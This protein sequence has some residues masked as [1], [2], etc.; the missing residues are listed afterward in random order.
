MLTHAHMLRAA[1]SAWGGRPAIS[2]FDRPTVTYAELADQ[3]W[4][5]A[6]GLRAAGIEPGDRVAW[7]SSNRD[8][9]L[10]AYYGTAIAGIVFAPLNYWLRPHEMRPLLE[11]V[12]PRLA[13]VEPAHLAVFEEAADGLECQLIC[14]DDRRSTESS[15]P[16][17]RLARLRRARPAL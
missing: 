8:E 1:V 16:E 11:L 17:R 2:S 15:R 3:S 5:L 13:F 9:Y 4:R 6:G 12:Q 7:L 14:L 10:A